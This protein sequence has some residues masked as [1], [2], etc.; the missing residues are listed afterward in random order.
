MDESLGGLKNESSVS[1]TEA[2]SQNPKVEWIEDAELELHQYSLGAAIIGPITPHNGTVGTLL[3]T[4]DRETDRRNKRF[5]RLTG[6]GFPNGANF[7]IRHIQRDKALRYMVTV[8]HEP[9]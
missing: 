4:I 5:F 2:D 1:I 8:A 6:P 3:A 7:S 9:E